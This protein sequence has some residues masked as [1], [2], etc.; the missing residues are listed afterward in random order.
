MSDNYR[1]TTKAACRVVRLDPQRLNEA[2]SKKDYDFAPPT[3]AGRARSFDKD[4]MLGLWYFR[5]FLEDGYSAKRAGELA[6]I[7]FYGAKA[8][9]DARTLTVMFD[10]FYGPGEAWP[11]DALPEPADWDTKVFSGKDIREVRTYR[12]GKTRDMISHYADE[13][14]NIIGEDDIPA[15]ANAIRELNYRLRSGQISKEEYADA[16]F[17]LSVEE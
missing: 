8:N 10:Y 16:V 11:T 3:T 5:E 7:L 2:I 14:R 1:L 17:D 15:S 13:E 6:S 9:P 12:I 4:D